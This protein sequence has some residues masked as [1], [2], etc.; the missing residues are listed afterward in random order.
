M[1][2]TLR[3]IMIQGRMI[4][5]GTK[6]SDVCEGGPDGRFYAIAHFDGTRMKLSL[7]PADIVYRANSK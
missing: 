5:K 6:L 3:D 2:K 1:Y 7:A 4:P